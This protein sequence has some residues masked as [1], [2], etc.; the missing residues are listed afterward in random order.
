MHTDKIT[1]QKSA[2][3]NLSLILH[4]HEDTLSSPHF[5]TITQTA[6]VTVAPKKEIQRTPSIVSSIITVNYSQSCVFL[7]QQTQSTAL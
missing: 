5:Y 4:M 6:R 3:A 1:I 2:K 7:K